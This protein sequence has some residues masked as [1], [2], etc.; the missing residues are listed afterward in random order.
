MPAQWDLQRLDE[1]P[2]LTAFLSLA[3]W[4]RGQSQQVS[5]WGYYPSSTKFSGHPLAGLGAKPFLE[6][7]VKGRWAPG[8]HT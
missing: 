1:K 3:H 5:F 2:G 6:G 4:A 8:L 7:Q